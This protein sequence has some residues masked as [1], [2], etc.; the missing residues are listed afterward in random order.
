MSQSFYDMPL[1][2]AIRTVPLAIIVREC[3]HMHP[4]F[5]AAIVKAASR[6]P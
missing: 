6:L 5:L 2:E 3:R 1:E 4:A